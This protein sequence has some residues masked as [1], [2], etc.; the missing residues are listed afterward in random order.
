MATIGSLNALGEAWAAVMV[1]GLVDSSAWFAVVS[2]LWL[3]LRPRASAAFGPG[4]VRLDPR[5][6]PVDYARLCRAI[7]VR[8]PPPVVVIPEAASPAVW[9][10]LR[11]RLIVP[12]GLAE[13]LSEGQLGWVLLHE[14]AHVRRGD[15]WALAVQR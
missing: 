9:G 15:L 1:R 6:L 2:L 10:R 4:L 14:L 13:G 12:P 11:P 7:G 3:G 5:S 8:R